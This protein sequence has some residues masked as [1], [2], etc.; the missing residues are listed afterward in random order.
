MG[1]RKDA[2]DALDRYGIVDEND[3]HGIIEAFSFFHFF[4]GRI[5][6]HLSVTLD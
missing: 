5:L 1:R 3:V 4:F 6:V 2:G